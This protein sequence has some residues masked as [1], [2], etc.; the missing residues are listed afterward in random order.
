LPHGRS[1]K[2]LF[3]YWCILRIQAFSFISFQT[4]PRLSLALLDMSEGDTLFFNPEMTGCSRATCT[5]LVVG[6]MDTMVGCGTCI[7]DGHGALADFDLIFDWSYFLYT[8]MHSERSQLRA[9][10]CNFILCFSSSHPPFC[11]FSVW[12][13]P[14]RL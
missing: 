14:C 4:K 12:R 7:S 13:V 8:Q 3:S 9:R 10:P 5:F 11:F 6:N 1:W 2:I